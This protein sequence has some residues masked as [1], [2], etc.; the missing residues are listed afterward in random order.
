MQRS[1]KEL[2]FLCEDEYGLG[3]DFPF[4]NWVA[5]EEIN[6]NAYGAWASQGDIKPFG[7]YWPE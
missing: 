6:D 2:L 3:Y 4:A 5:V 7:I 1:R